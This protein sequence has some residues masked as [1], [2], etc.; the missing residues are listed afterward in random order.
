MR[1]DAQDVDVAVAG[2]EDEEYVD[3]LE[4]DAIDVEE[5]ARQYRVGVSTEEGAPGLVAGTS[6]RGRQAVRTQDAADRGGGNLVA[7][8]AQP[9][10]DPLIT[11]RRVLLGQS[12]DQSGQVVADRG[13]A[14]RLRLAPFAGDQ[15]AVPPQDGAGGDQ[16]AGTQVPGAGS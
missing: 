4:G 3:A 2:I 14:R 11:P 7:Q 8:A 15:T 9:A 6:W 1:G 5:I 16:S 13:P 10:L 12:Y